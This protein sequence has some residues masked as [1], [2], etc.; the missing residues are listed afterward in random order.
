MDASDRARSPAAGAAALRALMVYGAPQSSD[1][2]TDLKYQIHAASGRVARRNAERGHSRDMSDARNDNDAPTAV[3]SEVGRQAFIA[4]ASALAAG[5]ASL[6][7]VAVVGG[8]VTMARLR[9]AGLRRRRAL[10]F[11][12]DRF[13]WRLGEK[14][15]HLRSRPQW[16]PS[17]LCTSSQ[18]WPM[19]YRIHAEHATTTDSS[20]RYVNNSSQRSS[21][22]S[23][24]CIT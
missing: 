7:F 2:R 5:I 3:Y 17:L 12:P 13:S 19:R 4:A 10:Q 1:P 6:T 14:R 8:A 23:A 18:E 21:C 11:S 15:L 22:Y 16:P 20:S 24:S 9:G